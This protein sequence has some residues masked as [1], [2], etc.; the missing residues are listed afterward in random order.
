MLPTFLIIGA[1]KCGTTSLYSYLDEHPEVSMS[2]VKE[3]NFFLEREDLSLEE[4]KS[5]FQGEAKAYGEASTGYTKYP[6]METDVEYMRDLLPGAKLIYLVRDPLDRIVS[7]FLDNASRGIERESLE[8]V[9]QEEF[10]QNHY[11]CCSRYFMQLERYRQFYSDDQ[12][13]VLPAKRLREDRRATLTDVF[14]FIGVDPAY[15]S[16]AYEEEK[17]KTSQKHI[18][19]QPARYVAGS[20]FVQWVKDLLPS[21]VVETIR[22]AVRKPVSRPEIPAQIRKRLTGYLQD[23]VRQLR[24]FADYS[25]GHWM[26][27]DEG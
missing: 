19:V 9:L 13:L 4:Y 10:D 7:H 1:M 2:S 23:D 17:H 12:I 15:W 5:L 18:P 3:P 27:Y 16:P 24:R 25:F 14:K 21:T 6:L 20:T 22:G 11:V 8:T 26:L